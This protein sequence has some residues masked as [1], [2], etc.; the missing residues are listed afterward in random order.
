MKEEHYKRR[1]EIYVS[2]LVAVFLLMG[3]TY[4][5]YRKT[6]SQ[7]S[8]ND[9]STLTCFNTSITDIT[10]A[11]NLTNE[12]PIPDA[13][14]FTKDPYTFKVTNNC[15]QYLNI[16]IGVETLSTSGI[17]ANYIKASIVDS[18][19]TPTTGT[20][21]TSGT[22]GEA[23]N[24][25]TTY[26]IYSSTL[27]ANSS[28]NFDL[29][30]WLNEAT[31]AAQAAGKA[32]QG[33]IVVTATAQSK[34]TNLTINMPSNPIGTYSTDFVGATWNNKTASLEIS[35]VS[36]AKPTITLTNSTATT[37]NLATYIT[38]LSGT[39]QGTGQVVSEN[40][41]RYE[42]FD[43]NNY[44]SFNGE[45]WR[46]IG[47]FDAASHGQTGQNLVKIIRDTPLGG[48]AWDKTNTNDWPNSSL[49]HLLNDYYYNGTNESTLTYCYGY[50]TSV[51]AKCNFTETGITNSTY[52]EMI[53][54]VTWYLGGIG[55]SSTAEAFYTAERG[56]T[57]YS[58]RSTSTTGNI[59][60]MYM[61]D[62][63]YSVL[64][65]SCARSTSVGSYSSSTCAGQSW[66]YGNSL[67][68]TLVSDSSGSTKVWY[69]HAN[70]DAVGNDAYNGYAARPVLY[71]KSTIKKSAGDGSRNNPYIVAS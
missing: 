25:G 70:G 7:E 13:E 69:V 66:L 58:G 26:I 22:L 49:Y 53:Q 62:Y 29:R 57:V 5:Y 42:G 17:L 37:T 8:Q 43:P 23:V 14:G 59:G 1:I 44:I 4:A 47:V 56:T 18:G 31:T 71:L 63:G 9:I 68:W 45:L 33:K 20:L 40:G 39:T 61:S 27:N 64:S 50:S 36:V 46:I 65:S 55:S 34:P 12:Y 52:R 19:V 51:Q 30:L 67:E 3:I 21:L 48:Y 38:G 2:L 32:Y 6:I 10:S 24:G 54:N 11:I 41:Y 28:K 16:S 60:L 15:N 35:S